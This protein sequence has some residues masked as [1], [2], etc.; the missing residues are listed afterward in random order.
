MARARTGIT[1]FAGLCPI[2]LD[3]HLIS[4]DIFE[5]HRGNLYKNLTR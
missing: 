3:D 1:V 4:N 5:I 2:Q